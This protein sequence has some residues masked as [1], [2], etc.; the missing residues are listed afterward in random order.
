MTA[1][2][3]S[4]STFKP[5]LQARNGLI[6]H[7]AQYAAANSKPRLRLRRVTGARNLPITIY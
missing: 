2:A 7:R 3:A 6:L 1:Q 5:L 4:T